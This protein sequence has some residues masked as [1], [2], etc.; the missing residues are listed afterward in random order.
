M[1]QAKSFKNNKHSSSE[2]ANIK[3]NIN[4]NNNEN[5][6]G[7]ENIKFNLN[8]N[9]SKVNR[10]KVKFSTNETQLKA[11][12]VID[13]F[14]SNKAALKNSILKKS[15]SKIS[16][17]DE[18]QNF[19]NTKIIKEYNTD[20]IIPIIKTNTN[21]FKI[22]N[23]YINDKSKENNSLVFYPILNTDKLSNKK[24]SLDNTLKSNM[25]S[26]FVHN[27]K[28]TENKELDNIFD[29]NINKIDNKSQKNINSSNLF[30]T[31]INEISKTNKNRT[32]NKNKINLI[33]NKNDK[34]NKT[35]SNFYSHKNKIK[36]E[37]VSNKFNKSKQSEKSYNKDIINNNNILITKFKE[38]Q[39]QIEP[40]FSLIK[41][42][43]NSI[44]KD[45]NNNPFM[46][47]IENMRNFNQFEVIFKNTIM[48]NVKEI[49]GKSKTGFFQG[50]C[51]GV[52]TNKDRT[53]GYYICENRANIFNVSEM[54]DRMNPSSIVKFSELLRKDYKEFLGYNKKDYRKKYKKEDKLRIK[55][56]RKYHKELFYENE[57]ADKY[58]IKKNSG[59]KF[60]Q[61]KDEEIKKN[62]NSLY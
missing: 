9:E 50:E 52:N 21:K 8:D 45:I 46:R 61:D 12:I 47:K 59:I 60:I 57:I 6:Q 43:G 35:E 7:L 4:S 15:S 24:I 30:Q 5:Y 51:C 20:K 53:S 26:K 58:N 1:K 29:L 37:K 17:I 32:I 41:T 23:N 44:N 10:K 54:I 62:N 34:Y 19:L 38:Y 36:L 18:N 28:T 16:K 22:N 42:T 25:K 31:S 33:I 40:S 14:S 39:K 3:I 49:Y 2:N 56:I 11:D 13:N 55:L 27:L 48:N